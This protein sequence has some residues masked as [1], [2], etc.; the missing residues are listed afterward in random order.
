M[1]CTMLRMRWC[2][3]TAKFPSPPTEATHLCCPHMC[4][5]QQMP[6]T[7][8]RMRWCRYTA[9]FPSPPTEATHLCCPHPIPSAVAGLMLPHLRQDQHA[10]QSHVND[11]LKC[12]GSRDKA[13]L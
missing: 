12:T 10:F 9:K 7:M 4:T 5:L 3:Y 2:R 8:L 1:P 11:F 6:C 13:Q